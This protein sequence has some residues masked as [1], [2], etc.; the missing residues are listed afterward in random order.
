MYESRKRRLGD[1]DDGYR[2][3]NV[4]PMFCLTPF[5]MKDRAD[6]LVY[7]EFDC[8]IT[9]TDEF[10]RGLRQTDYHPLSYTHLCLAAAARAMVEHPQI[11][12]FIAGR[13]VFARN[14]LR[15]SLTAKSAISGEGKEFILI[16][17]VDPQDTLIDAAKKFDEQ[18]QTMSD[19]GSDN[20]TDGLLNFLGHFP[21]FLLNIVIGAV[22]AM[23]YWGILP[24][25]LRDVLPFYSSAYLTNI[26]SI[27]GDAVYHHLYNFGTTS[28]FVAM[29]GKR[30]VRELDAQGNMVSRRKLTFRMCV[31]ERI[32]EG[33]DF[34][35][36]MRSFKYYIEHPQ[37]LMDAPEK[38]LE[39]PNL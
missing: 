14:K 34:I 2:L 11:N 10:L 9:R 33:Y 1:R 27:G 31:D 30:V 13:R 5:I 4:D 17:E 26:G 37:S 29:G 19:D 18:V 8:D 38:I 3:R 21:R 32:C 35:T 7:Y 12:R 36:A 16:T 20:D 22:K 25:D 24:K 28:V 15:F 6:A 39:D 23:D